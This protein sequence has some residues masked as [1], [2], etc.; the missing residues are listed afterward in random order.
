MT[1]CTT[2]LLLA[3]A[4]VPCR[5]EELQSFPLTTDTPAYCAQLARQVAEHHSPLLDVQRLLAEGREMCEQ[6]Q[7]R[8][9]IRRLRRAL[10]MLRHRAVGKGEP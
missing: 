10:V 1:R 4:A 9:G 2:V 6:G 7:I 8:G 3:V 5:A